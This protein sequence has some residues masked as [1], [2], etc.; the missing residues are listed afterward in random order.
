MIVSRSLLLLA[1]VVTTYAV[2]AEPGKLTSLADGLAPLATRFNSKQDRAQFVAILSPTRGGCVYGARAVLESVVAGYPDLDLGIHVVW[3]PMLGGDDE[4]AARKISKMFDDPRVEQYWDPE[5]LLGTSY[6]AHVF[7]SYLIDMEKGL[8]AALPADHWWREQERNWKNTKPRHAPLWDVAFTYDKGANW[9]KTP[10]VPHEM[11]KQMFF[12]GDE[13]N[14][15]TGM[16]FTDFRKPPRDGDWIAEVGAAMTSLVGRKPKPFAAAAQSEAVGGDAGCEGTTFK[17]SMIALKLSDL[18]EAQVGRVERALRA[19]KGVLSASVDRESKIAT[20]FVDADGSAT[21]DT[22]LE[23]LERAGYDGRE[24]NEQE[25]GHALDAIRAAG[26]IVIQRAEESP[27]DPTVTFPDTPVGRI[28]QAFVGAFN[29]GDESKMRAFAETHRSKS[30]LESA[31]MKERLDY[32]RELYTD[33]GQLVVR[34]VE[35]Y[36]ERH[37]TL[38]VKPQQGFSGLSLTFRC[39]NAPPNKLEE[40]GITPTFFDGGTD[41]PSK[42]DAESGAGVDITVLTESLDPLR[43]HFN[44]NKN[45]HRFIAIL[46]PT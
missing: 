6:S 44:A 10:P 33:W 13:E 43:D 15:P 27:D 35:S 32:Y 21:A 25:L 16:F 34:N 5:R 19:V 36:D 29:S 22:L 2:S 1:S 12:Y 3:A 40:I 23:F 46:S 39:E 17:V 42:D 18:K 31:S 9:G 41:E 45:K 11:I 26:P 37:L 14:G 4:E 8:N 30:A 7:P 20:V 24:A 28:A 38:T